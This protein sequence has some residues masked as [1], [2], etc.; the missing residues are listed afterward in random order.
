MSGQ[1]L[2]LTGATGI[3][4]CE[5]VREL[6][7]RPDPPEILALLRGE[8]DEIEAKR[9]WLCTW[10]EVPAERAARLRAIRGDVRCAGLGIAERD[11][12]CARAVTGILHAAAV[13]R[14]DQAPEEART[15]NLAAT[16][17]VLDHAR[18]CDRLVRV[19][20]LSTAFVAGRRRGVILEE[21]LDTGADFNNEYERSK[22]LAEKA[23]R[24]AMRDLPVD[25]Y[26]LSIV[27]GRR[28]D[29]HISQASG[30]YPI[31][32]L[33]HEGL[34][35]MFPGS[36]GQT[37]DLIPS[38]FAASAVC[39]LFAG[40]HAP[41]A[42]YHVCAGVDRSLGL[43]EVFPVID[44]ILLECDPGWRGRGQPLPLFVEAGVF[45]RF[46]DVAELTGNRRLRQIIRQVRQVTRQMEA[47]KVFDT[48]AF[49]RALQGQP[50]MLLPHARVWMQQVIARGFAT[51]W[52]QVVPGRAK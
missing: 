41:G 32:R 13:T 23:A 31:F 27:V 19:G 37:V 49:D 6:L 25:V 44:S 18:R 50:G 29:G 8:D 39:H 33:F 21:D 35:A 10:A 1:Q 12:P 9:N 26:R 14:F 20:I 3:V 34:L 47:P 17:H 7:R 30:I 42:T 2:L 16:I 11:L 46:V 36:P 22:A 15:N 43:E 4:G 51:G 45:G 40:P 52:R 5:L 28:I 48:R 24:L 38:D